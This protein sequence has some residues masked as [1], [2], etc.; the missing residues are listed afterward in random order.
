LN[1]LY[2][3]SREIDGLLG[4]S[5]IVGMVLWGCVKTYTTV[6]L[7]FINTLFPVV[8]NLP[9]NEMPKLLGLSTTGTGWEWGNRPID[10][11]KVVGICH[12]C[13]KKQI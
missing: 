5:G 7:T 6:V 11:P 10:F 4:N 3:R 1:W 12:H 2:F 13:N 8:Y 9:I